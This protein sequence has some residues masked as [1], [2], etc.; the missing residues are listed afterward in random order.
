[1]AVY[2]TPDGKKIVSGSR[3]GT[4]GMWDAQTG[5]MT[6]CPLEG[7]TGAVTSVSC[8]QDGRFIVSGSGGHTVRVWDA[9]TGETVLGPLVGHTSWVD[10]V[11][12]SPDRKRVVSC[13][14][15]GTIR[16]WN[17]QRAQ[18]AL[19]RPIFLHHYSAVDLTMHDDGWIRNSSGDLL[20]WIPPQFRPSLYTPSTERII[21]GPQTTVELTHA[22]HHGSNWLRCIEPRLDKP[23]DSLPWPISRR[24][25]EGSPA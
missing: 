22:L 5:D 1:M 8:S 13:S 11:H 3:G 6:S 20:L 9:E 17:V 21:G 4:I 10:S 12:F 24:T 19:S 25:A 18:P 23:L 2:F 15:D 14:Y 16:I 7:H